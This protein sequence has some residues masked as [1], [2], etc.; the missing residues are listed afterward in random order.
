VVFGA[1]KEL[2]QK[3]C[4]LLKKSVPDR[5]VVQNKSKTPKNPGQNTTKPG[6]EPRTGLRKGHEGVFQ[7]AGWVS[8]HGEHCSTDVCVDEFWD[9]CSEN[10]PCE[11]S[12]S[13]A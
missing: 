11:E 12:F 13:A 1:T 4:S 6:F 2:F 3:R 8:V 9:S 10:L 5:S 7:Q